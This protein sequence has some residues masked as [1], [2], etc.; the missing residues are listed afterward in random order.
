VTPHGPSRTRQFL[1]TTVAVAALA[2]GAARSASAQPTTSGPAVLTPGHWS[3]TPFVGFGFSG[4]L[5]SATGGFGVAGGYNWDTRLAIETEFS[6]LPSSETDGALEFDSS[7]WSLSA[8]LLYHFTER[9]FVPYAAVGIGFGHGSVDIDGDNDVLED[10]VD[11]S[12]TSF[13]VN[14]G[15]GVERSIRSGMGFRG[16]LRYFTGGDVVPDHWRLSAGLTFD[17]GRRPANTGN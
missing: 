2:F 7:F 15:A 17:L 13:I 14:F 11:T 9:P 3:V 5:D 4:D 6:A 10:L 1:I 8:N 16:D 12:D